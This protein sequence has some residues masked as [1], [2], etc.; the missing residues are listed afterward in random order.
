[1]NISLGGQTVVVTGG[2]KRLGLAIALECAR[3]GA[4]VVITYRSSEA[5]ARQAIEE[6][7]AVAPEGQ[8]GAHPLE[9]SDAAAVSRFADLVFEEYEVVSGL[10]NNAA[11]FRRTPFETL[12]ESDFDEHI[13]SNLKGPFLLCQTFGKRFLNSEAGGS[14][15]NMADIHATRPLANYVPYCISKAGVVM[16]TQSLAKALAPQVRVN[17]LCPG[18]ILLPS[19]EQGEADS[20]ADLVKRIPFGRLG[21]AEEIALAAVFLLGGPQF[22]TG[23]VLP[24]DGAQSLR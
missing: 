10:V 15:V 8:F 13:A 20:E 1:L 11:I 19:E 14:I 9:I 18:T 3:A 23:A 22:I 4:N 7:Q 24:V 17:C 2:A 5:Q 6:L 12:T 21:S 16:L